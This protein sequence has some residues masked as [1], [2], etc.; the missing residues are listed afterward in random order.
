DKAY[1]FHD[2]AVIGAGPAG[3]AAALKAAD[4]GASVVLVDENPIL[5]GAL[6]YHRFD[7]EGER[8]RHLRTELTES[9]L[10]HPNITVLNNA[11]CNGWFTDN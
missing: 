4:A 2:V 5:G 1:L 10:N 8:A 3:L 9:T 11:T 7:V 6:S